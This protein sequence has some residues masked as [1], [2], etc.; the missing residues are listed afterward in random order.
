MLIG[1]DPALPCAVCEAGQPRATPRH[2]C[3][4]RATAG[5]IT[6]ARADGWELLP[7]CPV[8]LEELRDECG[9][10]VAA[11]PFEPAIGG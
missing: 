1:L 6:P 3:H 5:L 4:Q 7:I 10:I 9:E 11:H 8:H 2:R